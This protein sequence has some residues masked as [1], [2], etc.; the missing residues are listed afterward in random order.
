M[1]LLPETDRDDAWSEITDA[2][3]AYETSAGLKLPGEQ[4]VISGTA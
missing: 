4:L 2:F 1:S 3:R